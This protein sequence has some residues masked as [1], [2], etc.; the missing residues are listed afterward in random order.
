MIESKLGD[1]FACEVHRVPGVAGENW[2]LRDILIDW[3]IARQNVHYNAAFGQ[4]EI[5]LERIEE[6]KS[7]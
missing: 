1:R 3:L 7:E 2:T 4:A 6:P 5:I